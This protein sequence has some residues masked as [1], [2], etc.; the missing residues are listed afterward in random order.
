MRRRPGPPD[1][2][3]GWVVVTSAFLITGLSIG[4]LKNMGLFFLEIQ[5]HFGVLTS[6]TSWVISLNI[7]VFHLGAPVASA[8]S[9][10]FSHRA[11]VMVAGLLSASGM[12]LASLDLSVHWLYL[13]IGALAGVGASFSWIPANILVNRYF[14]RLRPIAFAVASA[15]ECVLV[16]IFSPFFQWLIDTYSWQGALLIIGG[17]QLNI[18][19]CGALM[20]PLQTVQNPVHDAKD[21]LDDKT[22]IVAPK[23]KVL[24]QCSLLRKPEF[25]MYILFAIFSVAG[26]FIPVLFLVPL[27]NSLCIEEYWAASLLSVMAAADLMGRLMCGWLANM[28]L[29]RNLQLLTVVVALAGVVLLLMPISHDYWAL[30]VFF[31]LYGFLFGGLVAIHITSIVDVVGIEGFDSGLGLFMLFRTVGSFVGPPAAGWLV[32]QTGDYGSAFYMSGLCL[33]ASGVFVVLADRLVGKRKA[34]GG[35]A[36]EATADPED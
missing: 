11:V 36:V 32:D 31:S 10:R 16:T 14:L 20:R 5:N 15:G 26:M 35:D 34:P 13:S 9:L 23:K 24:F 17:I 2:G 29:L 19:V 18:C 21:G 8:L 3:Y 22:L 6:T 30:L 1:G 27:A 25:L 12:V 4:V 33:V 7:A 28:R